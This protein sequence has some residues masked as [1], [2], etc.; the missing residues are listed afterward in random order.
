ME[1]NP[2]QTYDVV[3][4]EGNL[5][6]AAEQ[7]AEQAPEPVIP[8]LTKTMIGKA[9]KAYITVQHPR[10]IGCHHRLDLKRQPIHRNCEH[11]WWA[12]FNNN[13]DVVRTA[14]EIVQ[15]GHPELIV[16][17]QGVKFFKN[18]CK[19]MATVAQLKKIQESL[20]PQEVI[21]ENNV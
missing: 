17:L 15:S 6:E 11:C 8:K 7:A 2:D 1:I 20:K 21:Q 3:D 14:D 4:S 16:K 5:V 19:F 13:A 12:W 9:R 10:S 18:F